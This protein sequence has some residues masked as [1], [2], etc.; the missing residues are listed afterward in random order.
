[1]EKYEGIA[2]MKDRMKTISIMIEKGY[3]KE[4]I[5]EIGYTEEEYSKARIYFNDLSQ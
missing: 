4:D 3:S 1:M 2:V 5:L